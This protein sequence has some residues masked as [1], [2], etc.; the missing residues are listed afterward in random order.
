MMEIEVDS[1]YSWVPEG[2][3]M[4]D[5]PVVQSSGGGVQSQAMT[6]HLDRIGD[7]PDLVVACDPGHEYPETYECWK[8]QRDFCKSRG[9][10]FFLVRRADG[11]L[12]SLYE[13]DGR[14]FLPHRRFPSCST[15]TKRDVVRAFLRSHGVSNR[16]EGAA[17]MLLG[18]STDEEGRGGPSD[19]KWV[20][21]KYPLL[22]AGLS[23]KD[24]HRII[25]EDWR[26]PEVVKSGCTF[27]PWM[28]PKG[29]AEAYERFPATFARLEALEQVSIRKRGGTF[30][31]GMT[32]KDIRERVDA[33]R[34]PPVEKDRPTP[35][36]D[37]ASLYVCPAHTG[38]WT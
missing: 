3:V 30:F 36:P 11:D 4:P 19:V 21:N 24:C 6:L 31:R 35:H 16:R 26:G 5:R 34:P 9:V 37:Q 2:W 12:V 32:L 22:E 28:G 38:C 29:M 20:V 23:R 15:K 1:N 7:L 33:G 25:S 14:L 8:H 18:I 10:P 27:C 17:I 13:R